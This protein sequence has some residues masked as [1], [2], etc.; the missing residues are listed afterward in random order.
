MTNHNS[1]Y[2]SNHKQIWLVDYT[3]IQHLK[4]LLQKVC[5]KQPMEP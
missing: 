5:T 1:L 2:L 4:G 3:A